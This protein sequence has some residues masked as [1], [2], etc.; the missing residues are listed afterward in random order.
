MKK[1]STLATYTRS[2]KEGDFVLPQIEQGNYIL[3]ITYPKYADFA[4][5][6]NVEGDMDLGNMI[7]TPRSILLQE[8]VIRSGQ[9]IRIRGDTTEFAADSFC[10]RRC[11]SR[12]P[13]EEIARVAGEYKRRNNCTGKKS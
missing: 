10:K 8:V 13:A 7:L 2:N 12:R 6:Y 9:A 4:D 3:L 5:E 11:N 1:D